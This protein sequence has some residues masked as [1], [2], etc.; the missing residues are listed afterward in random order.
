ML[1]VVGGNSFDGRSLDWAKSEGKA[2]GGRNQPPWRRSRESEG[3]RSS[4]GPRVRVK[5]PKRKN[6]KEINNI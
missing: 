2:Y 4:K 6:L 1:T 3:A 5:P